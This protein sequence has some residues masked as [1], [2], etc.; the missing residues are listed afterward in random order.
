[1][2]KV[3]YKNQFISAYCYCYGATRKK[4]LEIFKNA[5][6]DY[7]IAVIESQKLDTHNAFFND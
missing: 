2:E 7:I 5:T 4:A 3:K 6:V 1:M